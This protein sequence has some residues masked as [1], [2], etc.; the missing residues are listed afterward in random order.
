MRLSSVAH[1]TV[2][3]INVVRVQSI[4]KL[5]TVIVICRDVVEPVFILVLLHL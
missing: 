5:D 4:L 2:V 1:I 3:G